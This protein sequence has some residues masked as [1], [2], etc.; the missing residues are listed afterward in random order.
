MEF[1]Y[2]D[3]AISRRKS[4]H[5][6][7]VAEKDVV[8]SQGTLLSDV[9]L[10]PQSLPELDFAQIDTNIGFFGKTLSAP[11]MITSMTG[12]ADYAGKLNRALAKA[13]GHHNIALAVGSQRVMIKHPEVTPDFAVR[14]HIPDGVLLGNIGAVQLAEY[15][16]RVIR[17]LVSDIDADGICVHLNIA[18]ELMQKEG[19]RDF[20]GIIDQIGRLVDQLEGRVIVKETGA[21][22][23][24]QCLQ[25]LSSLGVRYIDVSG[26]GG[27]SWTK[28][29]MYRAEDDL[30]KRTGQTFSD[31]GLPTAF[32]AFAARK[33][34]KADITVIASGG[35]LT[36]LDAARAIAIGADIAGIARPAL[37]AFLRQGEEGVDQLLMVL[38]NELRSAMLLTGAK[39]LNQLRNVPRLYCGR[40]REM[41]ND[42]G[43]LKEEK[44]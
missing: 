16:T 19:H 43:W 1:E 41:L 27:T 24:P 35:I 42:Y 23:S 17:K 36:G 37:L 2:P 31:W 14:R 44:I 4:E 15:P 22:M 12:G 40:L 29:E 33:I 28:V 32:S 7:L 30:L 21:G 39:D 20:R 11:L 10:I 9:F 5:L 18:Q 26:S 8:H 34:C 3:T 25:K 38:K 6:R 13:A